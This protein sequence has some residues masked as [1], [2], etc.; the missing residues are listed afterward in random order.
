LF[1]RPTG[2]ALVPV[3]FFALLQGFTTGLKLLPSGHPATAKLT[4]LY[5]KLQA[6]LLQACA[7]LA[8]AEIVVGITLAFQLF[9]SSRELAKT[10]F[11][12][13]IILRGLFQCRDR[14]VLRLKLPEET[15]FFQ[16]LAW[17]TAY[18]KVKPALDMLPPAAGQIVDRAAALFQS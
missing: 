15:A 6:N 2:L 8:V 9:T 14:V 3:S 16:R 11:Y 4:L 7:L 10:A 5:D 1:S 12:W 13:N 18:D 17:Q